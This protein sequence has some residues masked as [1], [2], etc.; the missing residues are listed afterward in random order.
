[1]KI[2]APRETA[3]VDWRREAACTT[4]DPGLFFPIRTA[5]PAVRQTERAK[6]FCGGCP[7]QM[8]CLEWALKT[9]ADHGVWG[10]LSE[11]DRQSLRRRRRRSGATPYQQAISTTLPT[12]SASRMRT[13]T[14]TRTSNRIR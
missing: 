3:D 7:V 10:G 14:A 2:G 1:M 9:G 11:H 5:G 12:D 8:P 13:T 6:Q 4:Q